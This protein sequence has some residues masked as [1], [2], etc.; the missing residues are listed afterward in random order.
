MKCI[1]HA[2]SRPLTYG[3]SHEYTS[4]RKQRHLYT[5]SENLHLVTM[6]CFFIPMAKIFLKD[7][8]YL[9]LDRGERREKERERNINLLPP[10]HALTRDLAHNPGMCPDW[11]S[12]W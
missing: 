10:I 3:K 4:H 1:Y 11:E 12:N 7:F 9:L 5:K 6:T 8:I 2:K